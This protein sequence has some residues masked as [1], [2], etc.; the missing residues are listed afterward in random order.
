MTFSLITIDESTS[1]PIE[2]TMPASDMMLVCTSA[3]P[4]P[5]SSHIPPNAPSTTS[6]SVSATTSDARKC[7]R[8]SITQTLATKIASTS[9]RV[10]VP[11]A[12]DRVSLPA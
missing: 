5:R 3:M 10:T 12:P 4:M 11:T 2:I 1:T 7:R 6:G 8:M 9:V